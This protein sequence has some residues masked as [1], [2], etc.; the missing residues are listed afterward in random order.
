MNNVFA[1]LEIILRNQKSIMI[2]M[3]TKFLHGRIKETDKA[4]EIIGKM[5]K[6]GK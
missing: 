3:D 4:L 1:V 2:N 6:E 5:L